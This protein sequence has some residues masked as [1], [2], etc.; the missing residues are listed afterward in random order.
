[1]EKEL[2]S[3]PFCGAEAELKDTT[4]GD[5]SKIDYTIECVECD[6]VGGWQDTKFEA[7]EAWNKRVDLKWHSCKDKMPVDGGHVIVEVLARWLMKRKN[8][9]DRWCYLQEP[10]E[11]HYP[12][13]C[14]EWQT[15]D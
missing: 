7:V 11:K 9:F 15:F 2:R 13:N 10:D 8:Y 1:M 14:D 4:F 3:C 6:S 5:S 12:E